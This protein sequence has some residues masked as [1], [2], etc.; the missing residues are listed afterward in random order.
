[1]RRARVASKRRPPGKSARAWLSP[2]LAMTNGADHGRQQPQARLG[3][4]EPCAGLGDDQVAHGAQAHP[5]TQGRAVDAGDDG[6][7]AVVDGIEHLGKGHRV[8]LVGLT[9]QLQ[10][11][12]HP[13]DV[14]AGAEG[15]PLAGQDDRAKPVGRFVRQPP[16]RATEPVDE[17]GIEGVVDVRPVERH[18]H[19]RAARAGPL[20]LQGAGHRAAGT[21]A[22]TTCG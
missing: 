4:A 5:A 15:R 7:R 9:A 22:S 14:G 21:A 16:E 13:G 3:E 1:M 18:A 17:L 20:Q 6:H 12:A 19:D 2:I 10:A 8:G 11:G